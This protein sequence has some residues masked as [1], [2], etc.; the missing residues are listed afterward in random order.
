MYVLNYVCIDIQLVDAEA[1]PQLK[2]IQFNS[3]TEDGL[4]CAS[5]ILAA[6]E[7]YQN[8]AELAL[9]CLFLQERVGNL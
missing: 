2:L 7:C 3:S 5:C 8:T 9:N 4:K 1:T 6:M